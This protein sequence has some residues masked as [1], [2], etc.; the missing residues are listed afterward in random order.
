MGRYRGGGAPPP[1]PAARRRAR[2]P[3]RGSAAPSCCCGGGDDKGPE[4]GCGPSR[5]PTCPAGS[6]DVVFDLDTREPLVA[7]AVEQLAP[8]VTDGALTADQVHALVRRPRRRGAGRRQGLAGLRHRRAGAAS[9]RRRGGRGARRRGRRR[10]ER[11][12][13]QARARRTRA[14]PRRATRGPPSTSASRACRPMP[15]RGSPS[16]RGSLLAQR[17]PPLAGTPWARSLRDGAAVLTT[18]GTELRVPFRLTGDPGG[19][20]PADLPIA[21]GP[22]PPRPAAAR[23]SSSG[24]ATRRTRWPSRAPPGC[25]P[26]SACSTS[27][28]ASSSPT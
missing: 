1:R 3:R 27:F 11:R 2:A 18:R 26:S 12:G 16:I 13:P 24:C 28:P 8:R 4:G 5:S 21:T 17:S 7:L 19:L 10:A 15:A 25:C 23:R 22:Q 9:D 14:H 6:A 20:T